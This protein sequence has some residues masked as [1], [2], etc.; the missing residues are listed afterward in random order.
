MRQAASRGIEDMIRT[1]KS[2]G[3]KRLWKHHAAEIGS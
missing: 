3:A 2:A 1:V